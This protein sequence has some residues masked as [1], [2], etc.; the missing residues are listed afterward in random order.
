MKDTVEL[1]PLK[2]SEKFS[3]GVIGAAPGAGATFL[4]TLL[5]REYA[6]ICCGQAAGIGT[7]S[8]ADI[9]EIQTGFTD[10]VPDCI[11]IAVDSRRKMDS[12]KLEALRIIK[13]KKIKY[14][15]VLNFWNESSR[16]HYE[17]VLTEFC[18]LVLP[19]METGCL[20]E[21]FNFVFYS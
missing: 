4:C 10:T 8:K 18:C 21:M 6:Q 19:E 9:A 2:A 20:E 14:A 1:Q 17:A 7:E 5:K 3:V 13:K 15:V 11:L 16:T 12:R